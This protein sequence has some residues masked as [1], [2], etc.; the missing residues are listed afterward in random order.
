MRELLSTVFLISLLC[1]QGLAADKTALL[2]YDDGVPEDGM[3]I[4]SSKGH[5]V[6]FTTPA[7]NWTLSKVAISGMLNPDSDQDLFVL[8]IWD[9]NLN[10]LYNKADN[11]KSYFGD[12]LAWAEIDVPDVT[13]SGNFFI[14]IFEF[15][16]VYVGADLS[17]VSSGRSVVVSR[18]PNKIDS[19]DLSYPRNETDWS[20]LALGHSAA[21]AVDLKLRSTEVAVI[22]EAI[23]TDPDGDLAGT[24]VQ[25]VDN[26][27]LNVLWSKQ[28]LIEGETENLTFTWP[29]ETFQVGNG[30]DTLEPIFASNTVGVSPNI[31]PY[32]VYIAPCL[33]KLEPESQNIEAAAYFG[34]DG[35]FHA[36]IDTEGVMHYMSRELF[37]IAQPQKSYGDYMKNNLTLTEGVSALSFFNFNLNKGLTAYPPMVLTRSPVQHYKL[38]LNNVAV[39]SSA[40]IIELYIEDSGGNQKRVSGAISK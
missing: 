5:G 38:R 4:D 10:L 28:M 22:V 31:E 40:Y 24:S 34:E 23:I 17:N 19:W 21:P 33:V 8:E 3:W 14:C 6:L 16:S 2:R 15:S 20:I 27:N 9:E 18:N 32:M 13:L 39:S 37:E 12:E 36:L 29:L 7:S 26:E 11:P 30:T 35:E 1:C 25:I